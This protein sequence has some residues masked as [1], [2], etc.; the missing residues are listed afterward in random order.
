[1]IGLRNWALNMLKTHCKN[2][3]ENVVGMSFDEATAAFNKGDSRAINR[4]RQHCQMLQ[5]QHPEACRNAAE[6]A[7]KAFPGAGAPAE[8]Q[9]NPTTI[10]ER[11]SYNELQ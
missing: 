7:Q 11:N 9:T 5:Q 3:F 1:M 10:K 8:K 6:W 2:Q 4:I